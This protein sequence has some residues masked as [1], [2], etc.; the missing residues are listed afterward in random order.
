RIRP[1][2]DILWTSTADLRAS[3][4]RRQHLLQHRV[5]R[6]VGPKTLGGPGDRIPS[7]Y[8]S[9]VPRKRLTIQQLNSEDL[10]SF[11]RTSVPLDA[12]RSVAFGEQEVAMASL[13]L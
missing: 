12:D 1:C 11:A 2:F 8:H 4:P 6:Q 5:R 10:I 9:Q 13:L 3:T 7:R